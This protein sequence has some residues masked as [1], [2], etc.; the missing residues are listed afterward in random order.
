MRA[1]RNQVI[2]KEATG[3]HEGGVPAGTGLHGAEPG[4]VAEAGPKEGEAAEE[5]KRAGCFYVSE[6]ES[7]VPV[8]AEGD[9]ALFVP[10]P[11]GTAGEV[12]EMEVDHVASTT[13]AACVQADIGAV[14]MESA[15]FRRAADVG[16]RFKEEEVFI[17][18]L[19]RFRELAYGPYAMRI[20]NF[21]GRPEGIR[22]ARVS[23][24]GP[25]GI[26]GIEF[27]DAVLQLSDPMVTVEED[28]LVT[29]D[30]IG[31]RGEFHGVAEGAV[32]LEAVFDSVIE[33]GV[34]ADVGG[35]TGSDKGRLHALVHFQVIG[36]G[37]DVKLFLDGRA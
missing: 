12:G 16:L 5:E 30:E 15:E 26:G 25:S 33:K 19:D 28:V 7:V 22:A 29:K 21:D 2:S 11:A 17:K 23:G 34:A 6:D 24:N 13:A 18:R 1:L 14:E 31:F 37:D 35:E 32:G 4:G 27:S 9:P 3:D 20:R 10:L 36:D 8:V